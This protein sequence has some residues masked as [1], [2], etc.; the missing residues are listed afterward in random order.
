MKSTQIKTLLRKGDLVQVI[1]GKEKGKQAKISSMR[2]KQASVTLEGL[3]QM[4]RHTR[5]SQKHPQGGVVTLEA[6]I[7]ISNVMAVDP[8]T[9]TPTRLSVKS[10]DGKKLRIAKKS[11]EIYG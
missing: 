8:K 2:L 1:A 11:G 10:V 5:P 9:G 7:H 3:N 6:P 4:K